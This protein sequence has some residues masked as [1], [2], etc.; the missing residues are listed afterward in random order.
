MEL[1]RF[2]FELRRNRRVVKLGR[3]PMEL[4]LLLVEKEG[5][6]VTRQEIVERLWAR[7]FSLIPSTASI[8]PSAKSARL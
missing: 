8:P 3:I 6:V 1:D 7:M 2:R 5:S 4:W